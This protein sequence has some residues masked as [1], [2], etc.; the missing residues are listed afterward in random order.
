MVASR[1][2]GI[3]ARGLV[4][5]LP[6]T[7]ETTED[8]GRAFG[9]EAAERIATA[10]GIHARR[11]AAPGQT[12]SDLAVAAIERL[13]DGLG[14]ARESI[15]LLIVVTQTGDHRL[16]ATAC[17]LQHR[18][19]FSKACA[20]LDLNLGCSGFVYGLWN[21][22]ATLTVTEA[23]RAILVAGDVTTAMTRPEDRA[24]RPL[25]GDAVAALALERDPDAPAMCFDL[26]TDGAGAPYLIT[27]RSVDAT[28]ETLFMDG[29]QVFAFT[30]REVP[31]GIAA[32]LATA[33][34]S[35]AEVDHFVLHQAN[36]MMIRHLGP[37]IGASPDRLVVALA[38]V[39]NTSSASIPLALAQALGPALVGPPRKLLL[40]GFGVG[41]SW[42]SAAVTWGGMALCEAIDVAAARAA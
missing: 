22:A 5:A 34:W 42:G 17:L 1:V 15:D 30:L 32:V 9:L 3:A 33:G 26:G 20:A 14:W 25:F 28:P 36:A 24:V 31:R 12:V 2:S 23:R 19:G 11:V 16:P 13:L 41:W 18:L 40:S 8:L 39:G 27:R 37:K 29:T 35:A 6:A 10:T 4:A 21:A 7:V 38:D